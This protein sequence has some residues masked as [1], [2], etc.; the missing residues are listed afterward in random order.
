MF[1][2]SK[3]QSPF[4]KTYA[5]NHFLKTLTNIQ[6]VL[7][8]NKA[9]EI[10]LCIKHWKDYLPI[11]FFVSLFFFSNCNKKLYE[12]LVEIFLNLFLHKKKTF[13]GLSLTVF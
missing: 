6:V 8:L 9:T 10:N 12:E 4:S 2:P 11:T 5:V 13:R 3:L 1:I 7:S